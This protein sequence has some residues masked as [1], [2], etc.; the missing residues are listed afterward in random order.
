MPSAVPGSVVTPIISILDDP[1]LTT[2]AVVVVEARSG[3][4][5]ELNQTIN[6]KIPGKFGFVL[7][8]DLRP[9]VASLPAILAGPISTTTF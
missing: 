1:T 5:S 8:T 6:F 4:V 3:S 2:L 7:V 9:V